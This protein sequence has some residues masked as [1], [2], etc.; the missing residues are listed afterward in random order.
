MLELNDPFSLRGVICLRQDGDNA[1]ELVL[2]MGLLIPLTNGDLDLSVA[3]L[4]G[5]THKSNMESSKPWPVDWPRYLRED[6]NDLS[7]ICTM[8]VGK[9]H[10]GQVHT[11]GEFTLSPGRVLHRHGKPVGA[12]HAPR[13]AP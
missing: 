1:V 12:F 2:V 9:C 13:Q 5:M 11:E 6:L 7:L 10:C 8:L 4:S 3:E